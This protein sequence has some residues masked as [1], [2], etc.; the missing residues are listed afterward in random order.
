[1]NNETQT[2][3]KNL[4]K[5]PLPVLPLELQGRIPPNSR[6][7]E[8]AVLGA[9]MLEKDKIYQVM[10]ILTEDHFYV[11]EN[12]YVFRSIKRLFDQQKAVDL[13]TVNNDLRNF[14]ELELAGG[15]HYLALLSNRVASAA[16]IEFHAQILTQKKVQRDLI[17]IAGESLALGY[18]DD[19]DPFESVDRV[20]GEL[21]NSRQLVGTKRQVV[22]ETIGESYTEI[23][24]IA[25]QELASGVTGITTGFKCLDR[26]TGGYQKGDLYIIAARPSMGKSALML[27]SAIASGEA[28]GIFSLE[29]SHTQLNRR[30]LSMGGDIDNDKFKTGDISPNEWKRLDDTKR[31]FQTR[32]A[33]M[34]D[35]SP[36]LAIS[37][38]MANARQ[39][40][41]RE[42]I[43]ILFIDYLQLIRFMG[44]KSREEEIAFIARQL[45]NLAK[46]LDI[47]VVALSQLNRGVEARAD[48]RPILSDLR[49]SG[50]IEQSAD[51][52]FL[53]MRPEFYE[54]DKVRVQDIKIE[55]N[56]QQYA[57]AGA[58]YLD[59]AKNRHGACEANLLH[60]DGPKTQFSDYRNQ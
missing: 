28:V 57:M 16:N 9:M 60:Y 12:Q 58:A 53:L 6:E 17:R 26:H 14:N 54:K 47:P 29:M 30:L 55:L 46:E 3:K 37:S 1:M 22:S 56:G 34:V 4:R 23:Q 18:V 33:I 43:K 8:E 35:D 15:S 49:E 39:W 2:Q 36:G 11:P 59:I 19:E 27:S 7:L 10:H 21:E 41:R 40:K 45:K 25:L 51:S 44:A 32:A 50:E 38:V 24:K 31:Y 52:V 5:K 20:I 42:D 48:K 13:L